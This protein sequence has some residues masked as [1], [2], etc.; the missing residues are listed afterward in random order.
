M[1]DED[2]DYLR[3]FI[4]GSGITPRDII[5]CSA[6]RRE[7]DMMREL[8]PGCSV[9]DL[10]I[11]KWDLNE[12]CDRHCDLVVISHVLLCSQDPALW[13]KNAC[14]KSRHVV[15]LDLVVG[16]RGGAEG[17]T[18]KST[19]DF[20]RFSVKGLAQSKLKDSFEITTVPNLLSAEVFSYPSL[21]EIPGYESV[22]SFLA[23]FRG[24]NS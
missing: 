6:D 11:S 9:E 23:L 14:A 7:T 24:C 3:A 10:E 5:V 22:I 1:R 17:E 4:Q 20:T 21:C 16:H 12:E 15:V 13:I 18:S 2:L 8:F 19:G